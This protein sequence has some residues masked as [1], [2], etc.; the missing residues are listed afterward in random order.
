[1]GLKS[2]AEEFRLEEGIRLSCFD[3]MERFQT[4]IYI[5]RVLV[6]IFDLGSC[7]SCHLIS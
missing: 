1:M 2:L 5:F 6:Y 3:V 7:I 4:G